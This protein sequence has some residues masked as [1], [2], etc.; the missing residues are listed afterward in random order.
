MAMHGVSGLQYIHGLID[1]DA[2]KTT[3]FKDFGGSS[4]VN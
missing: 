1:K 4:E 3:D 2:A